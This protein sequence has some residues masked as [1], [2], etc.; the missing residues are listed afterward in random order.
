[1]HLVLRGVSAERADEL[2]GAALEE[3]ET[4]ARDDAVAV[5]FTREVGDERLDRAVRALQQGGAR[6]L[7]CET[8]RGTLLDV[9]ETFERETEEE[10]TGRL[11]DGV[12]G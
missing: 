10:Q 9:L 7:S 6:I 5:S 4:A 2:L 12:T 3:F 8:E 1:V 11:R